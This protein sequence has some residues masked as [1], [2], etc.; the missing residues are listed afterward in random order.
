MNKRLFLIVS[1]GLLVLP[2]RAQDYES[3]GDAQIVDKQIEQK[4]DAA[5]DLVTR[6]VAQIKKNG[7]AKSCKVFMDDP[8]WRSGEL[9]VFVFD[10]E[11]VCYCHGV[12]KDILWQNFADKDDFIAAM[13]DTGKVGGFV[14][15]KWNNGYSRAYVKT[16]T[17][18]KKTYIIGSGLFPT[19]AIYT[20]KELIDTAV[21]YLKKES[22]EDLKERIN[23]PTGLLVRGNIHL[24]VYA[25]D[26]T[27]VADGEELAFINQNLIDSKT[28]DG[29]FIIRDIIEIAKTKSEGWYSFTGLNG[30]EPAR[31]YVKRIIDKATNKPYVL[32][33]GYY[34]EINDKKVM[35]LVKKS[36]NYL[37][38]NGHVTA[39]KDFTNDHDNFSSGDVNIF[40]YDMEGNMMADGKNPNLVGKNL[41]NTRDVDG[42]PIAKQIIEIAKKY[43]KGWATNYLNN[44]YQVAYIEKVQVPDGD[45]IIGAAY[46][47]VAKES[48]VRFMID[49]A[50]FFM[51]NHTLEQSLRKFSTNNGDFLRG[52]LCMFVYNLDGICLADGL[53][54]NK[55]WANDI[56]AKDQNGVKVVEKIVATAKTGGGWL[57]FNLNNGVCNVYVKTVDKADPKEPQDLYIVGS[58]YFE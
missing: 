31:M 17:V 5:K 27:C 38:A 28:A 50:A 48:F 54:L 14:N 47:P 18:G 40:V 9:Y 43:G 37:K 20:V 30:N 4:S 51:Q 16:V 39:F 13:L 44:S 45:Y 36:I 22:F 41:S 46:F 58:G 7:I 34:T 33:C 35:E 53:N 57:K 10:S 1:L 2:G 52:D 56:Q 15:Y 3:D 8:G 32:A 21:A 19:S 12:Q 42:R 26:G 49:D 23:N 11:G 24:A 55:I 25:Y 29:K 6:A